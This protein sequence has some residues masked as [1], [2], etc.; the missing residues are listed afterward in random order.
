M[1]E[2]ID[3]ATRAR[4]IAAAQGQAPFDRLLV[5]ATVV[6]VAT[7]E[8]RAADV[9]L[10]GPMIASVHPAG[11]RADAAAI[12]RLDGRFLAPGLIDAH[13]HFESSLM[14]PAHYAAAVLPRGTTTVFC[15]P[16]ELANVL[17]LDGVRYAVEA[18]R[19]LPL[20]FIVQAPSCVPSAPGLE[21]A[22]A[23]FAG[24][25]MQQMLAW[26]EVAGVA[27]V[28]DMRGVLEGSPRM[29]EILSAGLASGKLI[30]GHARGLS[31]PALQAYCAAGIG[32]D[33][34]IV[35]ADDALEKL[36]AGL[37]VELRGSHDYLL[38]DVVKAIKTLP[39]IPTSLTVCTDD[40]FPDY[41]AAHGGLDDVVRRL[42][43]Y[44]LAP[45]QA[46][47]CATVNAAY[48]LKREDLGLVAAGR[49]A[50]LIVLSDLAAVAVEAVYVGGRR[51]A[52]HGRLVEP[53]APPPVAAPT[54]TVRLPPLAADDFRVPVPGVTGRAVVR[55]IRGARFSTWSEV[56]VEVA[57]GFALVPAGYSVIVAVHRHGRTDA[58]PQAAILEDW[59]E[60]QGALA[61][62]YSHDCHNLVVFGRNPADMAAAA[63]ALIACG[64][65]MAVAAGGRVQAVLELPVAGILST[66]PLDAVAA[67]FA[68]LRA[69]ADQ[70]AE[71]K[72]PYRV[73]KA[74]TGAC[75]ACNAGP[76]L[77]DLGLTDGTTR[78][79]LP[80][81]IRAA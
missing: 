58:R 65:G 59:G 70:V 7:C 44:G 77:T 43:R 80:A 10:V 55:A 61:T 3:P 20:R 52:E 78:Q 63:N 45:V 27:E 6:D 71:W 56:A 25:E 9:G 53:P 19:G 76:H 16:H 34:E 50:D 21:T 28:M 42:I 32:G 66:K 72:P 81:L 69:A 73:F 8:L 15:D 48:R 39:V 51:V 31:G 68:A 26:P 46:V 2:P 67:E 12:D 57:D 30:E 24:P 54:G 5:G 47:R 4:A 40:V 35:S 18:S 33:H 60:W 41:L 13:V 75:L 1:I 17:G 37:T 64:G 74:V 49:R 23:A 14:T 11:S 62:T 22:G 79:V 36:R 38:P 29:V